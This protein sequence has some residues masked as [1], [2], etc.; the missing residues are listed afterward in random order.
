M[1]DYL[2]FYSR[3][4]VGKPNEYLVKNINFDELGYIRKKRVGMFMHWVFEPLEDTYF[5]N[6][7]LKEIRTFITKLYREEKK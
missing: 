2:R 1:S 6:G 5:T 4:I 3:E 7:C